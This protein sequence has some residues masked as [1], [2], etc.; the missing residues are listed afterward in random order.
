MNTGLALR[1]PRDG[2]N[3]I[4][5]PVRDEE[6]VGHEKVGQDAPFTSSDSAHNVIAIDLVGIVAIDHHA[7]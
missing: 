1:I 3:G 4:G 5:S 7:E 6:L 2:G